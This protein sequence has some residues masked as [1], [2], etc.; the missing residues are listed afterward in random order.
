MCQVAVPLSREVSWDKDP[1]V[2]DM[3]AS[4]RYQYFTLPHTFLLESGHSGGIHRNPQEL[5]G[6]LQEWPQVTE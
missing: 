4:R 3:L 6:I 5:S 1:I 2:R